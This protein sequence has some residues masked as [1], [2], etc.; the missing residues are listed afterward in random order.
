VRIIPGECGVITGSASGLG[1]GLSIAL[2]ERGMNVVI[3]D[4][5][6]EGAERTAAEARTY[7]VDA[8]AVP[9]DVSNLDSMLR[10]AHVADERF[11]SVQLLVNNAAVYRSG[12][13]WEMPPE[14][15]DWLI[16]VNI[17]GV[18][19]GLSAFLPRMMAQ[20]GQRHIVISSSTN[21]LWIMPGQGA[22][23]TTKYA[24]AGLAEALADD[25]A[26][27]GIS[28]SVICPGPMRT[29]LGQSSTPPSMIGKEEL[30][31][32]PADTE[33]LRQMMATWPMYEPLDVGRIVRNAIEDDEFW[34][35]T[36]AQGLE[37][38]E[39]RHESLKAAFGR[40]VANEAKLNRLLARDP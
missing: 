17:K 24:V 3:A 5:D 9:T 27:Q 4:K 10:L 35:L 38:I 12:P 18:L 7:G 14:D 21:G 30:Q 1:Y 23:N 25:L 39:A 36:H 20:S 8:V 15:W 13:L 31:N 22:Y 28:V 32:L 16:R 19:N 40:R 6:T 29:R 11:G 33:K 37:E 2:A 26:P 34:I